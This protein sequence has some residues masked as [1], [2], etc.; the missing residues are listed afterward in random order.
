MEF[1][2]AL[3]A[4]RRIVKAHRD[5]YQGEYY[6]LG[7]GGSSGSTTTV[8]K[9]D[10]WAGVQPYLSDVLTRAQGLYQT[11]TQQ[12]D[13]SAYSQALSR[14]REE[15]AG[16][17]TPSYDMDAYN[18][19]LDQWNASGGAGRTLNL[20]NGGTP[21]H[22]AMQYMTP[23]QIGDYNAFIKR[24]GGAGTFNVN[25]PGSTTPAP[26]LESFAIETGATPR[27]KLEDFA[28]PGSEGTAL[29]PTSFPGQAIADESPE[30]LAARQLTTQRAASGSPLT[31]QAKDYL[32]TTLSGG[33]L[34]SNPYL[35][36]TFDRAADQVQGRVNSAFAGSGRLGGG[37]NQ[38]VLADSLGDLATDIYGRAF[39]SERQR[40]QQGMIFAPQLAATD[41][42]DLSAL[43]Q[44]GAARDARAQ[45]LIN[46]EIENYYIDQ[47]A[48]YNALQRYKGLIDGNYGA[49]TTQT[50]PYSRNDSAGLAGGLL[51]AASMFGNPFSLGAGGALGGIGSALTGVSAF[52]PIAFAAA[53]PWS[54]IRLKTD[55]KR[56]GTEKGIPVYH[57]RYSNDPHG[58]VYR[59]VMAQEVREVVPEA[60]EQVGDYFAVD[61]SKL[62]IEFGRV[63]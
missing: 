31:D 18:K 29:L 33:F 45:D 58:L 10:P 28:I 41:Y 54:D 60:V 44:V 13:R 26:T 8:E 55:I 23:Q 16:S 3:H 53:L 63:Y 38:R 56:V 32:N 22:E 17:L 43:S 7:G 52:N 5:E 2:D 9:S 14:W 35:D 40:Q 20:G 19:A 59:G 61:Y 37:M 50:S 24:T 47:E 46:K 30:T 15:N 4:A 25:V 11:P 48:P 49:T 39:D 34:F 1:I 36:A 27:P 6:M 62:G 21:I 51:G 12:Y 42:A 57:F